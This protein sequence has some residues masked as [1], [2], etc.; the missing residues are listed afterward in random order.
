MVGHQVPSNAG[1]SSRGRRRPRG[2]CR[3]RVPFEPDPSRFRPLATS[4]TYRHGHTLRRTSST[5]STGSSSPGT[6]SATSCWPMRVRRPP[7]RATHPPCRPRREPLPTARAPL[8]PAA[9]DPTHSTVQPI[10]SCNVTGGT[11][12]PCSRLLPLRLLPPSGAVGLGKTA[13]AIVMLDQLRQ[14]GASAARFVVAPLS[15][16]AHWQREIEEWTDLSVLLYHGSRESREVMLQHEFY[17]TSTRRRRPPP[18]PPR[19]AGQP[20]RCSGGGEGG[21]A[22]QRRRGGRGGG[23]EGSGGGEGGGGGGEAAAAAAGAQRRR[24]RRGRRR[25]GGP[26]PATASAF[27]VTL[28]SGVGPGCGS[29]VTPRGLFDVVVPPNTKPGAAAHRPPEWRG[30]GGRRRWRCRWRRRGAGGGYR[31]SRCGQPKGTSARSRP[32]AR[33]GRRAHAGATSSSTCC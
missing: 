9:P 31:C 23:G 29:G 1:E 28:P 6:T 8:Q 22:A 13:Q 33:A 15:T 19:R 32:R 25:R 11:R 5:A 14:T 12:L 20:Q 2:A 30:R 3:R 27:L 4:P 16:L 10:S 26:S 21:T 18:P 24:R 17:L 7:R